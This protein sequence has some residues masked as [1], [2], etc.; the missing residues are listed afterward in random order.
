[1]KKNHKITV[2]SG[3]GNTGKSSLIEELNKNWEYKVF[4]EIARQHFD[5]ADNMKE[6]QKVILENE[7]KRLFELFAYT[8]KKDILIDR[9]FS[10]NL[11]YLYWNIITER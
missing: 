9:T 1:M 2:F 8:G 3:P 5:K 6:F 10:D 11:V 7:R 4:K